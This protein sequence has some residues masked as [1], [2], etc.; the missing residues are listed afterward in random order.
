MGKL[1]RINTNDQSFNFEETPEAYAGPWWPS[2][3]IKN[4]SG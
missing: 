4:N 3:H 1:L 2:T